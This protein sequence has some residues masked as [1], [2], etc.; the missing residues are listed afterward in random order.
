MV[1]SGFE[2]RAKTPNPC[3]FLIRGLPQAGPTPHLN[4]EVA[5][6]IWVGWTGTV[7]WSGDESW[8]YIIAENHLRPGLQTPMQL[9]D[10]IVLGEREGEC[11][12]KKDPPSFPP[13]TFT[14]FPTIRMFWFMGR[15]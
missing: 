13:L 3:W 2:Q 5:N 8:R 11:G 1:E 15:F 9:S 10:V 4:D 12:I 14:H 7:H 6:F